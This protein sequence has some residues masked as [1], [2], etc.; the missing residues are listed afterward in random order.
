MIRSLE[1][2]GLPPFRPFGDLGQKSRPVASG[3]DHLCLDSACDRSGAGIRRVGRP[4][5]PD[6][7]AGC[8]VAAL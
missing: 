4:A 1:A 5:G 8:L 7:R 6:E 3:K 2:F